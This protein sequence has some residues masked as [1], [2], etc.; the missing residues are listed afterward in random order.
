MNIESQQRNDYHFLSVGPPSGS[1][2]YTV[3]GHLTAGR[4]PHAGSVGRTVR[5]SRLHSDVGHHLFGHECFDRIADFDVV[6]ILNTD[7]A[8]VAARDFRS[9]F[10]EA[11]ERSDL[12]CEDDDV[13]AQETNFCRSSDFPIRDV[14]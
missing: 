10:L 13:I 12:A 3:R 5:A 9:V 11:L 2:R 4:S 7:A 14:T 6:E 8:F 1:L